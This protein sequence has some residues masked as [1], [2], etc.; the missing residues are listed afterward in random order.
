MNIASY[1]VNN[2]T[3][4]WMVTLILL[5]GGLIAFLNL[6]RL[7]D[8]QFTIK[9]AMVITVY[10]GASPT[11]VEEEVT[12]PIENAIQQLPY[13]D[14]IKS[15]ST[16]GKSQITVEM[17]SIYRK[18]DL[19]GI[20]EE[21]RRK[22][23]DL[24]PSLPSGVYPP[25]II[26]DFADVYG[27]LIAVTGDGYQYKDIND[28]VDFL[29]RELVL[30]D[31]VGKVS[32]QGEQEEQVFVEI[33]RSKIV[34][35]GISP[36]R[37]SSLLVTQ[38]QVSNAG[39]VK[40]GDEYIR[41]N[42]TGEFESVEELENLLISQAGASERIYLGD[43][44]RVYRGYEEVPD[45][46]I[47]YGGHQALL[48]GISFADGV[49]V[50]EVG[51]RIQQRMQALEYMRPVGMDTDFIYNQPVEV[52]K[53][54]HGFILNLAEAVGI[55]IVVLLLFMGIKSGLLIGLI[56]LLTVL[57]TFIFM[58]QMDINLQRISLGALII[59]L[60]MLVDN[61]IVVT[62]GILI[63][64]KR[65][66]NKREAA[67]QVVSQNMWPLLGATV[68]AIIAFAPIGL[69]SDAT[70]E[71]AGSLF[72][73]LFVSLLL[74]WITAIT[75]TPFFATLLF[76]DDAT[77][78]SSELKDSED[79]YKGV[80]FDVFSGILGFALR[81]RVLTVVTMVGLL[82]SAVI[83]FGQV[84]QAFFPP[85]TTPMFLVDVWHKAGTDIRVNAEKMGIIEAHMLEQEG[86]EEVT[87]TVGQGL[88]RFMLTYKTEKSYP[89]Y[90]QLV[91]RMQDGESLEA[92]LPKLRDY[93]ET[94][95]GEMFYKIKR[96]E[97]GPSTDAK[98]E[99]RFSGPDPQVLR[100]L[101]SE[102]KRVL[103]S[104]PGARNIRDNWRQ[105][106]KVI[107]PVFNE[108]AARR[109]GISK[110][111]LDNLL[112]TSFSGA[113]IGV[114]RDGTDL[115][116][117]ISR[118]PPEER[119][120][121]DNLENLQIF[122][123]TAQQ[124]IPIT[125]IVRKFDVVWEDPIIM[126]RDR[127]RTLT[128]MADHDIL[129]SET[130]AK[131]FS[132]VRGEI[133]AIPLPVGYELEWGGEF[134]ASTK[135]QKAIFG[136]LPVGYLIMFITTV[137]LFA[138]ARTAGIIWA[139]IPLALIGVSYGLLI[140]GAP[141][142]F[143]A[144]LG[145]LSLSG[146]I[147]KNG[148]VLVEQVKLELEEGKAPYSALFHATLSRVRPV[149]MAAITTILG[150]IPLLFDD[151]FASMAVVIMFGLGFATLLTLVFVPVLYSLVFKIK[152]AH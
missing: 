140:T 40:I 144:L 49:N 38:N 25:K 5:L 82:V 12:Y 66:L 77:A 120:T 22:I 10:P 78:D 88:P 28:Y 99:A 102:T 104:D 130:A 84:K 145:F 65:G 36:S 93:M 91:I 80:I 1:F 41:I 111:D 48:L 105:Q 124:F 86:V 57:G 108:A 98:I 50:V 14:N 81:W 39:K 103:E 128:V 125:Q 17:K 55:V 2:R 29:K 53:S 19:R 87:T 79:I 138:S 127:K 119:L 76:K 152:P 20:W 3:S 135:A 123:S 7:E 15:I 133:E 11:Q 62:E 64:M 116:P 129:G 101:A 6:G 85:S 4:S 139:C 121:A 132:R 89:T 45:N 95:H 92:Q 31:G 13:V 83:A 122:S 107:R 141:F 75:L 34:S 69:S 146:M 33:S 142:G 46:L 70:G 35:L 117:I 21:M 150:M 42:P 147:I 43:V 73:V 72:W 94:E 68:I 113:Q 151:F 27:M 26:D 134:E 109:V 51:E 106:T 100:Q 56:L 44:A 18:D 54:V 115:L 118:P 110:A 8:P 90:A 58:Q 131:L 63:A 23:N 32:V 9:Q 74:S 52:D 24:T 30:V 114:Y 71:F 96:L 126:R 143:M 16:A 60:G 67:A 137:L 61:A 97:I 112:L 149:C 37:I 47:H 59:A 136:S 148:I